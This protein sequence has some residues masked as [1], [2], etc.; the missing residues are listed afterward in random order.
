MTKERTDENA[1]E[2]ELVSLQ[3]RLMERHMKLSELQSRHEETLEVGVKVGW[4]CHC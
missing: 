2:R 4:C 3:E 1:I